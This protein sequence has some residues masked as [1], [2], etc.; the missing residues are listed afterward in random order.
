MGENKSEA[1]ALLVNSR[2]L[3]SKPGI[4]QGGPHLE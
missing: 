1:S 2:R 3:C 4:S